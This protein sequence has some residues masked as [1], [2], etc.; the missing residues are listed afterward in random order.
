MI[1]WEEEAVAVMIMKN[2]FL[3]DNNDRSLSNAFYLYIQGD[4]RDCSYS[5][6]I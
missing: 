2:N 5:L 4:A 1:S 3:F 6:Q